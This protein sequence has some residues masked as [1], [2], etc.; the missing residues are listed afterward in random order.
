VSNL[1]NSLLSSAGALSAY[2]QVLQVT[3]NNV[4][5][6]STPGFVKHRQT[7]LAMP[8]DPA[9]GLGGGVRAG[10]V[11]SARSAYADQSVRRQLVLLGQAE[12]DVG[13]LSAVQS[14]FDISGD[15]GIPG[16]FN[17]LFNSFSTWAQTPGDS[18][19]RQDVIER[20]SDVATAFQQTAANL[21]Q[22]AQEMEHAAQQTVDRVNVLAGQLRTL[23]QL[24]RQGAGSDAGLDAQIHS[25][26]EELSTYVSFTAL[27]QDDGSVSVLLNGQTP[28]LVG[29]QQYRIACKLGLPDSP[30]PVYDNALSSL[31]LVA[32]DGSDI[33]AA[34]TTGQLGSLLDVRNNILPS[35]LGDA[36][37]AG[38]LNRLAIE[39]ADRVNGLLTSGIVSDGPPPQAGIALFTYDAN[40][41]LAA[42]TLTVDRATVKPELLAA[43]QTGPPR[44]GN[45]IALALS[46]LASPRNAADQIDGASYTQFYGGLASRAGSGVDEANGRLAVQQ[47][48]VAQAKNLRQQMSGV[49]LD[50]EATILIQFQR[51]YEANSRLI[52]VLNDLTEETLNILRR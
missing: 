15:A 38:G 42:R 14:A 41:A 23:N 37:Q 24:A 48:A 12:Q 16:A 21:V 3:Q 26:L 22:T 44:V 49:S 28:L 33:T 29:D 9:V 8:F 7:L 45:G 50:E 46:G 10:E 34:T 40:P 35:Y 18:V 20:A 13:S 31:R 39:F 4:A 52:G 47:S 1:L 43:I 30:P 25:T 17:R 36:W 11:Q 51:A 2:D 27:E 19:S 32:S 6:A 5:N